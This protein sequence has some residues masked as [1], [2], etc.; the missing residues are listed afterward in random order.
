MTRCGKMGCPVHSQNLRASKL[1]KSVLTNVR[2]ANRVAPLNGLDAQEQDEL[3]AVA[4]AL[5]DDLNAA[6]D[7]V[8]SFEEDLRPTLAEVAESILGAVTRL[9][10]LEQKTT[11]KKAIPKKPP[12]LP[13]K[14][15]STD[16]FD[17]L[18]KR[19]TQTS[20]KQTAPRSNSYPEA[21]RDA[22]RRKPQ[23]NLLIGRGNPFRGEKHRC[24]ESGYRALG[25][26]TQA[27]RDSPMPA[28]PPPSMPRP[29][30]YS[31][32]LPPPP[33]PLQSGW[34]PA[35]RVEPFVNRPVLRSS[36]RW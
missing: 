10:E 27:R 23:D 14:E 16:I 36:F 5:L 29:T 8:A 2:D 26:E 9:E 28:K 34:H 3:A 12:G 33:L 15:L 13:K 24:N 30:P 1:L 25:K 4:S 19:R 32:I 17:T 21:A 22:F 11:G 20:R 7:I 6:I 35:S 18:P 31:F